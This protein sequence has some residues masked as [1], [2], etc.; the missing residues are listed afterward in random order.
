MA[1]DKNLFAAIVVAQQLFASYFM[2]F[3]DIPT[4]YEQKSTKKR[5]QERTPYTC[6]VSVKYSKLTTVLI[7]QQ[8]LDN[9]VQ[10][11]SFFSW[12]IAWKTW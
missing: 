4:K 5:G 7:P 1:M 3:Y 12:Q 11:G 10:H 8:M 2:F 6:N 9:L